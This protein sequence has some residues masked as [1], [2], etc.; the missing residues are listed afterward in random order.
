MTKGIVFLSGNK[1]VGYFDFT[2]EF[3]NAV[4][5]NPVL[6]GWRNKI[7]LINSVD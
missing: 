1:K 5:N 6:T 4:E 3:Q 2:E 7:V